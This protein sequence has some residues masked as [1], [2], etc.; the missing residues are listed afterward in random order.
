VT[1]RDDEHRGDDQQDQTDQ[2]GSVSEEAAKLLGALQDWASEAGVGRA[3]AAAQGLVEGLRSVDD[4]VGHGED[5]RW[6][7][8]C[9]LVNA[10]R[11]TSPEVR[12]HLAVAIG[13]LAQAA[14]AAL[15]QDSGPGTDERDGPTHIDL[16]G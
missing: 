5:C 6:C 3:G 1:A 9:R 2:L 4:H 11:S 7:P 14:T 15:R 10:A 16:D 8:I 12:E 13:S